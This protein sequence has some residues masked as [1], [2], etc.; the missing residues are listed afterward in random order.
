MID[1]SRIHPISGLSTTQKILDAWVRDTFGAKLAEDRHERIARLVEEV[2]ELAQA[3]DFPSAWIVDIAQHVYSKPKGVPR[4]EAGGVFVTLL[5]YLNC[6][7]ENAVCVLQDELRRI[8]AISREVWE[9]RHALKAQKGIAMVMDDQKVRLK[10]TLILV[11]ETMI[12]VFD[13]QIATDHTKGDLD[14]ARALVHEARLR[15]LDVAD[16]VRTL[17]TPTG[18]P[19][20]AFERPIPPPPPPERVCNG[21]RGFGRDHDGDPC[22]VCGGSGDEAVRVARCQSREGDGHGVQCEREAGHNGAHACPQALQRHDRK[23]SKCCECAQAD[24]PE[25]SP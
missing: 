1:D 10:C 7:D 16:Y 5:A 11:R 3:E 13:A 22:D 4:L 24:C 6:I 14:Q 8:Y 25:C 12:S 23:T 17:Y 20:R 21:C 19:S 15:S 2:I 18:G 9:K